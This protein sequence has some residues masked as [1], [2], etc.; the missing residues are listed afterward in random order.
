MFEEPDFS[1]QSASVSDEFS[2]FSYH[3]MTRNDDDYRIMVIGSS[4]SSHCLRIADHGR[5][6]EIISSLT[7]GNFLEGFPCFHLEF[8]STRV[9]WNRE[10][11][12]CSFEIFSELESYLWENQ[13]FLRFYIGVISFFDF[14]YLLRKF[15]AVCEFKHEEIFITCDGIEITKGWWN[16]NR[17]EIHGYIVFERVFLWNFY[18]R[19]FTTKSETVYLLFLANIV[20][21]N[22]RIYCTYLFFLFFP[23]AVF[24]GS[25]SCR[26]S[27][28]WTYFA[29]SISLSNCDGLM[30]DSPCLS[31]Q[32]K[33]ESKGKIYHSEKTDSCA[34]SKRKSETRGSR[35]ADQIPREK[36]WS[37]SK[38]LT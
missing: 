13:I 12:S 33:S 36:D 38:W 25:C 7:M 31:K 4:D 27:T 35:Y 34:D 10:V 3:S 20:I 28:S 11:F 23:Y 32:S 18:I 6:F 2:G 21:Y 37:S 1:C 19:S 24:H 17:W 22:F 9:E 29:H 5:F 30:R 16:D 26:C 15:S 8:C 14:S